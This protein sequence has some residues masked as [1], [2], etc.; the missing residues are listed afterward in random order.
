M[1]VVILGFGAVG[2]VVAR[3]LAKEKSVDKIICGDINF[4][5][6]IN[7]KKIFFKK[8]NILDKK[9]FLSFLNK[10][11][12]DLVINTSLPGFNENIMDGCLKA[13]VNY[14][15]TCS[16]WDLD[17]N[18]KA[19]IPYKM[20]QLDFNNDFKK[21]G[22]AGLINAGVS[23]GLTN[24]IA[25][26]CASRLDSV[27]F[28][29]IR[30]VEDTGSREIFFSWNK[31]WLLDEIATLPLV[32]YNKKFK[33]EEPFLGE[34]EFNFPPPIG[35]RKVYYFCQDEVGTLPLYIK[36]KNL[37]VKA[38][39]NNIDVSKLLVKLGLTSEKKIDFKNFKIS[40]VQ[41]LSAIL[42]DSPPGTEKKFKESVFAF[43]VEATG[44][45]KGKKKILKY[46]VIFPRQKDI[47]KLNLNA[48]F[49]SYP[50]ALSVKLF[51]MA[52][53][54]IQRK[55][56]FP[57]EAIEDSVRKGILRELENSPVKIVKNF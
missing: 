35:K 51:A 11:K 32:Y 50:T 30:L 39:D 10:I 53:L 57:P 55:G 18:P 52:F 2:S 48:N 34:E 47:E 43:S 16:Y 28:M 14:F 49:I 36:M 41:F 29:K 9:G 13:G 20:E 33:L 45:S 42:P 17:E 56:V 3:L 12:P 38:F 37:D 24:L 5:Y 26:E 4:K 7:N 31:D 8:A 1:K 27:D 54:D 40:P 46:S 23:P 25:K 19:R 44:K 21:K 6:K 22:I 15:D